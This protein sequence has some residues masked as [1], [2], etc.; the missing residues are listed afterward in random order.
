MASWRAFEG[1]IM[2]PRRLAGFLRFHFA[3][4]SLNKQPRVSDGA[5]RSYL[6]YVLVSIYAVENYI[7]YVTIPFLNQRPLASCWKVRD[8][9]IAVVVLLRLGF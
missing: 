9:A 4:N 5:Y 6:C 1:D 7:L 8:A 2:V 3:T